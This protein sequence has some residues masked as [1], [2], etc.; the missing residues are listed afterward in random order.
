VSIAT[1]FV[2][3]VAVVQHVS[4]APPAALQHRQAEAA[5]SIQRRVARLKEMNYYPVHG[6]WT[7]M[8]TNFRPHE[9]DHDFRRIHHLGANTVR[10]FVQAKTFGFPKVRPTMANRLSKVIGMA[11]KHSL[12]VHL[13]LFDW[14]SKYSD[15]R[16]S[17]KWLR[18]LLSPYRHDRRIAVV[19]LKNEVN[20]EDPQEMHWVRRMLPYLARVTPDPLH[21]VSTAWIPPSEFKTFTHELRHSRPD[22]WDYHYYGS[23]MNAL[24]GLRQIQAD[25]GGR[26]LFIGETG[27]STAGPKK[28]RAAL[29]LQQ[30]NY[31][32]A[33]FAAASKL[34]L[35]V[36]TPWTLNDFAYG[37]IPPS[38][39]SADPTQYDFG[40]FAVDGTRKPAAGVVRK[41]FAGK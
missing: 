11:A 21:T 15:I 25:A 33:V 31:F 20:P 12:K 37:A 4:A 13:T 26:P 27:F 1:A 17:R 14:W 19:E 41:A 36:P 2:V 22:F 6:G 30:E 38:A 39:T 24:N 28:D 16:G 9:I 23:A 5:Q 32:Q 8:W 29:D 34:G 35:P 40:L 7:Y 18:S 3:I 10:V